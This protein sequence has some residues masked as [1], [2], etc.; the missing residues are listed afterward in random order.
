MDKEFYI[1]FLRLIWKNMAENVAF[2]TYSLLLYHI[3]FDLSNIKNPLDIIMCV[4]YN[5]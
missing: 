5:K 2:P 3:I 4:L 1:V